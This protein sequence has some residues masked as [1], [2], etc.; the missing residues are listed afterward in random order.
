MTGGLVAHAALA[1]PFDIFTAGLAADLRKGLPA[2]PVDYR[3]RGVQQKLR[4]ADVWRVFFEI[5]RH[6]VSDQN[7]V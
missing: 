1:A 4:V 6:H 5:D 7:A 3:V 2:P